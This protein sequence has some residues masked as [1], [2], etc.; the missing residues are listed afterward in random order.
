MEPHNSP[1]RC[2]APLPCTSK[3]KKW[4][5]M[6]PKTPNKFVEMGED[7]FMF[8]SFSEKNS[9]DKTV[10]TNLWKNSA[11]ATGSDALTNALTAA[12]IGILIVPNSVLCSLFQC[13]NFS[14]SMIGEAFGFRKH[15]L[16]T[17]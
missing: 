9:V 10:S 6:R 14:F 13:S 15:N 5:L 3:T 12:G 17:K 2:K 8:L 11:Q 1:C 16:I 7:F 4:A